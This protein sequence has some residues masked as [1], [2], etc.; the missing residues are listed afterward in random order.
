M[1]SLYKGKKEGELSYVAVHM[2]RW[3]TVCVLHSIIGSHSEDLH[4]FFVAYGDP[5][6]LGRR[7][8]HLVAEWRNGRMEECVN[9][10]MDTSTSTW[11]ISPSAA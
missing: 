11:F 10:T 3:S 7:P 2:P 6:G 4:L 8:L 9:G 1:I 5:V